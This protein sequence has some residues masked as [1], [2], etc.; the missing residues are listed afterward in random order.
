MREGVVDCVRGLGVRMINDCV[1]CTAL[2]TAPADAAALAAHIRSLGMRAGVALKPKT[3]V[4]TVVPLVEAGAVDM[5][6]VMTV[7]PGFGGQ[8][9]MADMMPKVCMRTTYY[10]VLLLACVWG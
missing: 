1:R 4:S 5:V 10:D 2:L 8:K 7:E 6:L 9:F 3:D